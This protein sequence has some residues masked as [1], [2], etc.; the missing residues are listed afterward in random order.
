[1]ALAHS[2]RIVTDG[3]VLAL[4]AANKK[5]YPGSGTTWFDLSGR[6]NHASLVNG[7]TF[8]NSFMGGILTDGSN[9]YIDTNYFLPNSNFT[10][11]CVIKRVGIS[12]WNPIWANE[13]YNSGL[14]YYA[15]FGNATTFT[16]TK[17][18]SAQD[19]V[20]IS[21]SGAPNIYTISLSDAGNGTGTS[22]VYLNGTLLRSQIL[23]LSSTSTKTVKIS[24]R[25]SNDGTGIV[26][27][28]SNEVYVFSVYERVLTPS[29]IR[30]N[31]NA[32][33]GRFGL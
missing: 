33:R 1:M 27:T 26:D 30:Q 21:Q 12:Y 18:L 17:S 29:E 14:G 22:S 5:S 4:D 25:H 3:L 20:T 7:P 16:F 19:S 24:T 15:F 6:G 8:S 9:D 2:P 28:R 32:L 10:V 13:I 23:T 31:F 11:T